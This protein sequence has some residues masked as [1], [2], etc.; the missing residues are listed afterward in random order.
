MECDIQCSLWSSQAAL[1]SVLSFVNGPLT[2]YVKLR[3]THAQGMPGTFSP[4]PY[5]S[6][7]DMHHGTCL[8]HVPWCMPGSLTSGFIWSRWRGKRSRHSRHMRNPQFYVSDKRPILGW[9]RQSWIPSPREMTTSSSYIVD[10]IITLIARFM[11]PTWGPSG[12]DR[13]Q[14]GPMLAP[15]TLLSGYSCQQQW[16]CSASVG[17][18]NTKMSK[19]PHTEQ[20]IQYWL[21][22]FYSLSYDLSQSIHLPVFQNADQ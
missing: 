6:D 18:S 11:G 10:N 9:R 7:P 21:I 2:R 3:F 17:I 22:S 14:M 20:T 15:W 4:P 5:V 12:A 19:S 13:T 1:R 8:T 16:Y